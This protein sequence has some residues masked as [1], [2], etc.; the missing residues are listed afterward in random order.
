MRSLAVLIR[1]QEQ[2]MR[3]LRDALKTAQAHMQKLQHQL[4]QL[5]QD[6][7]SERNYSAKIGA[8]ES[9]FGEYI[10]HALVRRRQCCESLKRAQQQFD[11]ARRALLDAW[12]RRRA[13]IL[14]QE[15]RDLRQRKQANKREARQ[16]DERV[17]VRSAHSSKERLHA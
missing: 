14:A 13:L 9:R 17:M 10:A 7:E 5:E 4:A 16:N 15:A 2:E 1:L 12:R 3:R 8:L 11:G 6:I